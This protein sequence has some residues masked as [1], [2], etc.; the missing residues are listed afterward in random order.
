LGLHVCFLL[1]LLPPSLGG[2]KVGGDV[3]CGPTE[4][5]REDDVRT[6]AGRLSRQDDEDGL[7]DLFREVRVAGLAETDRVNQVDMPR[8]EGFKRLL[9]LP[10]GVLPHPLHVVIHHLA[11]PSTPLPKR[12]RFPFSP[13]VA[14]GIVRGGREVGE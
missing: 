3:P 12:D 7:G 5:A 11:Y 4:P 6:E 9:G 10:L 13:G 2:E 14:A 1:A 8:D